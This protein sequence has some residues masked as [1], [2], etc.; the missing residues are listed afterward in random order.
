MAE[1]KAAIFDIGATL[2][3]GPPVAPNK[4]IARFLKHTTPAEVASVIMTRELRCADGVCCA[5]ESRFGKIN[6]DA[7]SEIE[8]LWESQCCAA[9]EIEGATDTV[10]ALKR[11]GLK[12]G[13]LSDIWDPYYQSVEKALPEIVAAADAIILSYKTGSRKPN[14]ENFQITLDELGIEAHQAVMIGDTYS[15]DIQPALELGMQ[16][17]WVLARPEREIDAILDILNNKSP[18]PTHTV[19]NIKEVAGLGLWA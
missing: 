7:K 14:K 2:V 3:T 11:R 1:I 5:I 10:L 12:I 6:A 16:A 9:R 15:H 8:Q 19:Y 18:V 13:L 4:V 17:V